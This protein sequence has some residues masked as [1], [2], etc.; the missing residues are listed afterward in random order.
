MIFVDEM[1][2]FF[3]KEKCERA[4]NYD[5]RTLEIKAKAGVPSMAF[6][7][8]DFKTE[9]QKIREASNFAEALDDYQY[10]MCKICSGMAK[11]DPEW[12]KYNK[13]RVGTIQLLT[14][15]RVNLIAFETDP[16]GQKAKICDIVTRLQDYLLLVAREI[17]PSIEDIQ[18]KS[19]ISKGD[20]PKVKPTTVSKALDIAGLTEDEVD[21]FIS[22][23]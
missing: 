23:S 17:I 12:R 3:R 22:E 4:I 13:L 6:S 21:C 9:V 2:G 7:L 16:E 18:S 19:Y 1:R 14:T 11:S 5:K 15:L 8:D 10:Q 20:I